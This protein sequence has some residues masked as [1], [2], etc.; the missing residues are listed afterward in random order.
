M[1]LEGFPDLNSDRSRLAAA[2]DRV[3]GWSRIVLVTAD[4]ERENLRG[5]LG[6]F[7]LDDEEAI[8]LCRDAI[9]GV[10]VAAVS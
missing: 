6:G 5:A 10:V 2:R 4:V 7:F 8:A 1:T 3:L 9:N